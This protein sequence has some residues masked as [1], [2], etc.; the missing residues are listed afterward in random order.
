[1]EL[2]FDISCRVC[3][4]VSLNGN[5]LLLFQEY[6]SLILYIFVTQKMKVYKDETKLP[7]DGIMSVPLAKRKDGRCVS[8][9]CMSVSVPVKCVCPIISSLSHFN[10]VT[11][12]SFP[13]GKSCF[14]FPAGKSCMFPAGKNCMFPAGKN[15]MFPAGKRYKIPTGK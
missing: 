5:K 14:I 10:F 11:L 4:C 13:A 3:V 9:T 12:S 1:M 2:K 15:C 6:L 8:P 7:R